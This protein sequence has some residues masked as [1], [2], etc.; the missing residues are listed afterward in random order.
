MLRATLKGMAARKARLILTSL[1]I[2]LGSAFI[3]A[4]LTLTASIGATVEH[5]TDSEYADDDVLVTPNEAMSFGEMLTGMRVSGDVLTAVENVDGVQSTN[6]MV[7]DVVN[8]LGADGKLVGGFAPTMAVNW[9]AGAVTREMR[10]GRAPETDTEAAVSA[11]FA[12]ESGLGVGDSVTAY[13]LTSD[14][15]AYTIVGVYGFQGGRDSAVGETELAFTTA[16][17]QRLVYDGDDAYSQISVRADAG[18]T[19]EELRDRVAAAIGDDG[20]VRTTEEATAETSA[21]TAEAVGI[22][23]NFLLGFGLVAVFVSVFLIANT[24]S[25]IVAGRLK[26]LAMM[27]AIGAGQGQIVRSVLTEALVLGLIASIVG[28]GLGIGGGILLARVTS[29]SFLDGADVAVDVPISAAIIAILIG[30]GVTL[31]SALVPAVRGSRVPPVAAMRDAVR[32]DKPVTGITIAAAIVLAAGTALIAVGLN[33]EASFSLVAGGAGVAFLGTALLTPWLSRPLVAALGLLWSWSFAGKLGRR[34]AARNPRRTAVT[35][36]ALMIGV[37]LVT[38]TATLLTSVKQSLSDYFEDS[39]QAE[40]FVTGPL[41]AP[42]PSSYD[43]ALVQ[44]MR[45]VDG[46]DA[47]AEYYF[48]FADIDGLEEPVSASTDFGSLIALFGGSVA[49]GGTSPLGADEI[50]VN[51]ATADELGLS[52]GD[53][54]DVTFSR[55]EAAHPLTLTRLLHDNENTDR[56]YVSPVHADEFFT[57]RPTMALIDVA[58][59]AD[60]DAVADDLSAVVAA[61]PEVSVQNH[62]EYIGQ[63]TVLFDFAIIAIQLLLALAMIVAVIGVIN[64]LVLSVLERTRELGVLRAIGM[65]RGQTTR[66]VTVES[67]TI[68]LFGALLGIAVGLGLGWVLQQAL[69]NDGV[70]VFTIPTGLVVGYLVAAVAVGLLAAIAPAVRASKVNILNAIAYE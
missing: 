26:E 16:E 37:A 22:V 19:P 38:A 64:T 11:K 18:V 48:D 62:Q 5:L 56:W 55:G 57:P 44:Q 7:A 34:N 24:F 59:G 8:A 31:L 27:R 42:I 29:S 30:I 35:A 4:A 54:V 63:L 58:D 47:V 45:A 65:T 43:P 13:S 17:A 61:E 40:L 20:R 39:V 69:A 28:A 25:I 67:V 53:T 52:V 9:E 21:S 33:G 15:S 10:E 66:M 51:A 70:D 3:A 68:A 1:A 14:R 12:S 32:T 46:V 50:A 49:D 36:A 6:P 60:L 2:V 23:G 41:F